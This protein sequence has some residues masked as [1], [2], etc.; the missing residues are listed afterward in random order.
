MVGNG[1]VFISHTNDGHEQC[2]AMY[3]YL[4]SRGVDCWYDAH[5]MVPGQILTT[6][7]QREIAARDVFL[8]VCTP[9]ATNSFYMQLERDLLLALQAA[10]YQTERKRLAISLCCAGYDVE[11]L[12]RRSSTA[13][14][15][16]ATKRAVRWGWAPPESQKDHNRRALHGAAARG[17]G[18][19]RRRTRPRNAPQF[20]ARAGLVGRWPPPQGVA[21]L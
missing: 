18:P 7:M 3:R 19:L 8:R 16:A 9:Q 20:P 17:D 2:T 1:Q 15:E 10:E 4:T 11:P 21:E 14:H 12:V 6:E 5:N 13:I